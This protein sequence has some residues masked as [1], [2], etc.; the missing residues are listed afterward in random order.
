MNRHVQ[1]TGVR[2]WAGDDLIEL[3]GEAFKALDSFFGQYGNFILSGCEVSG[4]AISPGIVV[5]SGKEPSGIDTLKIVPFAGVSNAA[6]FQIYLKLSYQDATREYGDGGIKPISYNYFAEPFTTIPVGVPYLTLPSDGSAPR[7][8]DA[9][10]DSNHRFMTDAEK[11]TINGN[12]YDLASRMVNAEKTP[13]IVSGVAQ[14]LGGATVTAQLGN[15]FYKDGA[16]N[17]CNGGYIMLQGVLCYAPAFSTSTNWLGVRI[18]SGYYSPG[19]RNVEYVMGNYQ[20][21]FIDTIK[22][23]GGLLT[24]EP[25]TYVIQDSFVSQTYTIPDGYDDV[26][27]VGGGQFPD[28]TINLP[29]PVRGNRI[30]LVFDMGGSAAPRVKLNCSGYT[31]YVNGYGSMLRGAVAFETFQSPAALTWISVATGLNAGATI[32]TS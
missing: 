31:M 5:L 28:I 4:N 18:G 7:F 11:A 2:R 17:G 22:T 3:Q 12:L 8:P 32:T 15:V 19:V 10:Q 21:V 6:N 1:M 13:D 27:V 25:A 14:S 23:L 26:L 24:N 29:N 20:A 9:I 30:R 16:A